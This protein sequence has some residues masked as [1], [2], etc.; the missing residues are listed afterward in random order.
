MSDGAPAEARVL[1]LTYDF[2][3]CGTPGAA[4]R[5]DRLAAY[6]PESGWSVRVLCRDDGLSRAEGAAPAVRIPTP[7]RERTSYQAAAW[8][9]AH[10]ISRS[11]ETEIRDFRPHAL[12][13]S[14]PPFPHALKAI[15]AGERHQIPVIVDFRDSW[16]LDPHLGHGILRRAVKW[17]A[18]RWAYPPFE[19]RL[20]QR[21]AAIILNTP[22]MRE[23]YQARYPFAAERMHWIP[24]G[25]D[26]DAFL[27][28]EPSEAF[29]PP[30]FLY[31]GRFAGIAERSPGPLL[32][33]FQLALEQGCP[34][35][36]HILGDDSPALRAWIHR[37]GLT[38]AVTTEPPVSHRSAIRRIRSATALAVYQAPG[39]GAI[40]PIA[41]KTFDYIRSGRPILGVMTEGDNATLIRRHASR[42]VIASPDDPAA[43]AAGFL[44]LS[45]PGPVRLADTDFLNTYSRRE[46][47]KRIGTLLRKIAG[48]S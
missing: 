7:I 13:A 23:A 44:E 24:N 38:N 20:F 29:G 9:W 32:K 16:T 33:G 17:A 45:E 21:S 28:T 22:A 14:C 19:T 2:S 48:L 3:P 42:A 47:A 4:I 30:V 37:L 10:R 6:L 40:Q 34:A 12:L 39:R 15:D 18:C 46:A 25:F 35:Q 31:A 26:D 5:M 1:I 8:T 36:L 41:G 27:D 11:L 43:I